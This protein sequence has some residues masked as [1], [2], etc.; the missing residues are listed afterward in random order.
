VPRLF[1]RASALA[2]ALAAT[3]AGAQA[4][5]EIEPPRW[6]LSLGAGAGPAYGKNYVVADGA[7]AYR[8]VAGLELGVDGQWWGSSSPTF[9]K[10]GPRATY[11]LALPVL[12][13][14]LGAY[15]AHWFGARALPDQDAV[16]VRAG[17]YYSI[18]PQLSA[19]LGMAYERLLDCLSSCD[20]WVP[21]AHLSVH[22]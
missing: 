6:R 18:A 22:F 14:Y 8:V 2:V 19:G 17:A 15:W 9:G 11:V 20:T 12:S 3:A 4:P 21:E 7:V 5:G 16:G 13:P 1:R 10:A